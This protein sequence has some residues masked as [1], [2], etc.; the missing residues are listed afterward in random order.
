[1]KREKKSIPPPGGGAREPICQRGQQVSTH[2]PAWGA[3]TLCSV[4]TSSCCPFQLTR[5][6]GARLLASM[7]SGRRQ[8]RFQLTRPRGARPALRPAD[9]GGHR[10]VSTHAPAWG[11]TGG[12]FGCNGVTNCF[13][14]RARVGRDTTPPAPTTS[15]SRVSTHAPAWG[16][17][18]PPNRLPHQDR[19][20]QLTR[21]RGARLARAK[22]P[23]AI[24]ASFNSRARV[25]RDLVTEVVPSF[26]ASFQLTRPRGA[27]PVDADRGDLFL[28]RF[29]LTRPR[30]ARLA[31]LRRVA[32]LSSGF[33]SRARVGRDDRTKAKRPQASQFQLTRPRGARRDL[34]TMFP[35]GLRVSTHA[36]A[37]GATRR[38]W[39]I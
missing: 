6:R 23:L 39:R 12:N 21:P 28:R 35:S 4:M 36:P 2:A 13:N 3:T 19:Q 25:G 37:W 1:M 34:R 8:A 9:L 29:Q 31:G 18:R 14:S 24:S 32:P 26:S 16:A 15:P 33:N 22:S 17:T 27:R 20:F 5:P 11:A 30:G 10:A 38:T 7:A